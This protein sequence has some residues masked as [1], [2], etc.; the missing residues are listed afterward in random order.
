MGHLSYQTELHSSWASIDPVE[1]DRLVGRSSPFLEH[2]F[3][4]ALEASRSAGPETG[5][6]PQPI[7]IR[8]GGDLVGAIP[9][10]I[11]SHGEGQYVYE[12]HWERAVGET[13]ALTPKLVVT[14]PFNPVT[15]PRLLRTSDSV[16]PTMLAA[17]HDASKHLAGWHVLFPD[18]RE[19]ELLARGGAFVRTQF[20]FHWRNLSYPSWDHFLS[21]LKPHRRKEIQRE[22]KKLVD[23]RFEVVESPDLE[24]LDLVARCY[25]NT[26]SRYEALPQMNSA[27]FQQI[28]HTWKDRMVVAVAHDGE[29]P[30]GAALW[31]RWGD[32][33]YGRV[34]GQ[35]RPRPFL[36]FELC[37]YQSV[38]YAI[39]HNIATIEPGHGGEHKF[40]RGFSPSHTYS[41]HHFTDPRLHRAF[42]DHAPIEAR[43]M[44]RWMK[45]L[46]D[47]T[48][49]RDGAG[50]KGS[51]PG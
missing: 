16:L 5:W 48:P 27:F 34:A 15:G 1:W 51:A 18:R 6:Q 39:E 26:A 43:A 33:L 42:A 10:W 20:Q 40:I 3:L 12:G 4:W 22:R 21:S 30:L 24:T 44:N 36:H 35:L 7:T 41:A 31:V 47:R 49:Y 25:A 46:L 45:D 37:Y 32:R 9:A 38:Q 2:A 17:L 19:A 8:Q 13:H 28:G 50:T 29:G 23:L 11:V 14:V